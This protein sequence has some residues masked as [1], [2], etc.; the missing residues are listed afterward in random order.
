ML[1]SVPARP[2]RSLSGRLPGNVASARVA[3]AAAP[4]AVEGAFPVERSALSAPAVLH[5]ASRGPQRTRPALMSRYSWRTSATEMVAID[6]DWQGPLKA[7]AYVALS[8]ATALT[9]V[10]L[11]RFNRDCIDSG[12]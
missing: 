4:G 7:G 11:L 3:A 2:A 6:L 9:G 8:R 1:T 5:C 10:F 12:G